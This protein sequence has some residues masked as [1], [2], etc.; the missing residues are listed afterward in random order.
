V[1]PR[2]CW[3]CRR[4]IRVWITGAQRF[5]SPL[6]CMRVV[7]WDLLRTR[8]IPER[9]W[10]GDSLRRGAI[11]SVCTFTFY[12]WINITIFH[13]SFSLKIRRPRHILSFCLLVFHVSSIHIRTIRLQSYK[14]RRDD[15][16]IVKGIF[17]HRTP[18]PAHD[19]RDHEQIIYTFPV[20]RSNRSLST[21]C[22]RRRIFLKY[23]VPRAP[24]GYG[25]R[26]PLYG[27]RGAHWSL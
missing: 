2:G 7:L 8:A 6:W 20:T 19:G 4:W 5:N 23:T 26:I 22:T 25:R 11:S 15:P 12:F 13:V 27:A 17:W 14:I 18:P 16:T 1:L 3:N 10:G 9:F 24:T 21:P